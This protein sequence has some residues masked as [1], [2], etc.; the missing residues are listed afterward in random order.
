M[1]AKTHY[2]FAF[3]AISA[4]G[5]PREIALAS[6]VLAILPD[7]DHTS[8]LIGRIFP[9]ISAPLM[10]R[11]GH[12]TITHSLPFAAAL[13]LVLLPLVFFFPLIYQALLIAYVS[14]IFIDCF[15]MA[16]VR[17]FYPFSQKEY[18]SFRT[19]RLRVKVSSWQEYAIFILLIFAI[20]A[21][22]G[23]TV[24]I[25]QAAFS[26]SRYFFKSYSVAY[27]SY[28]N[29]SDYQ[30]QAEVTWFDTLRRSRETITASII[31]MDADKIILKKE[32]E[33]L[34][35]RAEDIEKIKII[36]SKELL[37][38][39][40]IE[41]I[42]TYQGGIDQF[43]SGTILYENYV[44]LI[45]DSDFIATQR[46]PS[47]LKLTVTAI[48]SAELIDLYNIRLEVNEE[49]EKI[50]RALPEYKFAQLDSRERYLENRINT[51]SN[52]GLY[53]H[54]KEIQKLTAELNRTKDAKNR[55]TFN[56]DPAEQE[57]LNNRLAQLQKFKV[58]S[59]LFYINL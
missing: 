12:R 13:A 8:S 50:K 10:A 22:S 2:A 51:L 24:S 23:R 18:I 46:M 16:G 19:E 47:S 39:N 7:I 21:L 25:T 9:A 36:E 6:S 59:D 43:I 45:K 14:H 53:S 11:Y 17:L 40:K 56:A 49:I 30:T 32:R 41:S 5:V 37:V 42:E 26:V 15:N 44:P 58:T 55:L 52:E 28:R 38:K 4:V 35:L 3:L 57:A 48:T 1:T 33:R 20:V 27:K 31:A 34:V 29:A 54:Y